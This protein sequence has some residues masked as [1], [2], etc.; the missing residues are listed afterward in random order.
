LHRPSLFTLVIRNDYQSGVTQDNPWQ[1]QKHFHIGQSISIGFA[2]S[3]QEAK[4]HSKNSKKLSKESDKGELIQGEITAIETQFSEQTQA[5]I[6]IR[7]YDRS[8]RLHRGVHNRS[9]QN[10]TDS[11]VVKKIAEEISIETDQIDDSGEPHDYLFQENQSNMA[12][13]RSRAARLGFELFVRDG[14]LNFRRPQAK[15]E[16][17]KLIWLKDVRSFHARVTSTEQVQSVEVR[18]WDYTTKTPIVSTAQSEQLI[19]E[20]DQEKTG[21]ET[22]TVFDGMQQPPKLIVCDRPMFKRKEADVMAQ[23][24]CDELG[25]EFVVA[26][27]RAEGN[28]EIRPGLQVELDEMGP[29]TGKYYVTETRHVYA[30][31]TYDTE[32][33]VRGLRGGDFFNLLAPPTPLKP[34]QTHLVGIVTDNEDPA[35]MGRVKVGFPTLTEDHNS[36]WARVVSIGAANSRGFDCLPEINDE[37]LVAFEHGDIHRPYVLGGVWNGEDAPPN[38][39]SSNVQNGKVRLRT[40]QTRTGHKIQFVEEDYD[41]KKGIYVETQMGYKVQLN[42]SE[43]HINVTTPTGQHIKISDAENSIRVFSLGS[44]QTQSIG[45][46]ITN[47]GQEITMASGT[48]TTMTAPQNITLASPFINLNGIAMINS[49]GIVPIKCEGI[50]SVTAGGAIP[51]SAGGAVTISAA[52]AV[53]INSAG[54]VAIN[55]PTI[56]LNGLV[57]INGLMPVLGPA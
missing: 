3:L 26:D 1:R 9:F 49:P 42:E 33:S 41:T 50:F 40:F 31:R 17:L 12:F 53:T 6:I 57:K 56:S 25:G 44:I 2:P 22:S 5:P 39:A 24:L 34:G 47:A 4:A 46:N 14:K 28:P 51:I 32:F 21:S 27:A 7:G 48:N 30:E 11:D 37:V 18:G 54:S 16:P 23:S 36:N 29:Y 38:A 19:T 15:D 55:A 10:M 43:M 20:T 35:N 52:G 13:L 45:P 8:H